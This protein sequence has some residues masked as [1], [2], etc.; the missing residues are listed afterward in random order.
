MFHVTHS[1]FS[2]PI[3]PVSWDSNVLCVVFLFSVTDLYERSMA[4]VGY[5]FVPIL[6][7]SEVVIELP[8]SQ[9][10]Q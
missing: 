5:T 10:R 2:Y 1:C 8:H 6:S 7:H 4:W 3:I 9:V